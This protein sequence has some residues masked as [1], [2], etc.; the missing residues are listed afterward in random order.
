MIGR[1]T[2]RLERVEETLAPSVERV[3]VTPCSMEGRCAPSVEGSDAG[4]AAAS[5]EADLGSYGGATAW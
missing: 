4:D 1:L 3:V 5:N 2:Q